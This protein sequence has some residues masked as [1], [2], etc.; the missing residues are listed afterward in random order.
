MPQT[1]KKISDVEVASPCVSPECPRRT[2]QKSI[3][4]FS[5]GTFENS[6][7]AEPRLNYNR[8]KQLLRLPFD[9]QDSEVSFLSSFKRS[10][11]RFSKTGIS[12]SGRS[13]RYGRCKR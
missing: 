11:S 8:L 13:R 10:G 6:F 5:S 2:T 3:S 1:F 4:L 12:G 9:I 7:S